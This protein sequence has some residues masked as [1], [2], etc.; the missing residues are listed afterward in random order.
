[1]SSSCVIVG[2]GNPARG[3][4]AAGHEVL[5]RLRGRV[6]HSTVLLEHDGNMMDLLTVLQNVRDVTLIDVCVSGAP[7]G[8]ILRFDAARP[9]PAEL[10]THSTH[11]LGLG[12]AVELARALQVL[13]PRCIVYLI[14]GTRFA[15][16]E[17]PSQA[18]QAAIGA[19]A[20]ALA[21]QL[22]ARCT[23]ERV[24]S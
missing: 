15:L 20:Q 5:A 14:E 16:G 19:L 10:R 11:G 18:V 3:D 2:I 17:R 8:T 6:G 12:A 21:A 23:P 9:L 4:D 13:P 22:G 1:M 7:A 24:A